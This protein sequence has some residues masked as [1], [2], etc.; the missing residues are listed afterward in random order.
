MARPEDR[1]D[2]IR[3]VPAGDDRALDAM[4]GEVLE[5]VGEQ[6][7]VDDRE[8]VLAGAVGERPQPRSLTADED[9]RG[10]AHGRV[11]A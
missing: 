7:P 1:L 6:R 11:T 2:L 4:P 9:D 10:K 3:E 8:H 5:R